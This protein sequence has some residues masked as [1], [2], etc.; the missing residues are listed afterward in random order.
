MDTIYIYTILYLYR[1][2]KLWL[3]LIIGLLGLKPYPPQLR[4]VEV[5]ESWIDA[6]EEKEA[7]EKEAR[8]ARTKR[9]CSSSGA[10]DIQGCYSPKGTTYISLYM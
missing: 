1:H 2:A 7:K 4:Q 3:V 9:E 5:D 10:S 6:M 8:N